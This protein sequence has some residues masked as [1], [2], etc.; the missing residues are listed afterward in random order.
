[1]C[2]LGKHDVFML[3]VTGW[4]PTM[5]WLLVWP[6]LA[7]LALCV[8]PSVALS[9]D[10][11][12][13]FDEKECALPDVWCDKRGIVGRAMRSH[14]AHK[15]DNMLYGWNRTIVL[16]DDA[17]ARA[18]MA[19]RRPRATQGDTPMF[20]AVDCVTVITLR[21]STHTHLDAFMDRVGHLFRKRLH[22]QY[23]E[24]DTIPR[25]GVWYAHTRAWREA[26]M[27]GC[28]NLLVFEDDTTFIG[29]MMQASA[30]V[31]RFLMS[32]TPYDLFML[33]F[34]TWRFHLPYFWTFPPEHTCVALAGES[35][36]VD[37]QGYIIS[38]RARERFG[39]LVFN[40]SDPECNIDYVVGVAT[41][42]VAKYTLL[43]PVA[44]QTPHKII[45]IWWGD[46][47]SEEQ[48]KHDRE[49]NDPVWV[50][51]RNINMIGAIYRKCLVGDAERDWT[52]AAWHD[53]AIYDATKQQCV[54]DAFLKEP[55]HCRKTY[56]KLMRSRNHAAMSPCGIRRKLVKDS[57]CSPDALC[58][59]DPKIPWA[60]DFLIVG[61]PKAGTTFL[62]GILGY[63]PQI[64]IPEKELQFFGTP[65]YQKLGNTWYKAQFGNIT[66]VA[67]EK[68]PFYFTNRDAI[69]QIFAANPSM[70]LVMILRDP[71]TRLFSA[72]NHIRM[73][74]EKWPNSRV[75]EYS[76]FDAYVRSLDQGGDDSNSDAGY[77]AT[78]LRA[79]WRLFPRT[80]VWI[81]I[82]ERPRDWVGLQKFLGVKVQPRLGDN[83]ARA[84]KRPYKRILSAEA[85]CTLA[86][87]YKL[88]NEE[89]FTMLGYRI[90]E[91]TTVASACRAPDSLVV[92]AT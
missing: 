82:S 78:H 38:R 54:R 50:H 71:V 44:F 41:S 21:S 90:E 5:G 15:L 36:I 4:F 7:C 34:E 27:R 75:H 85:R 12:S 47:V 68:T 14:H 87:R 73:T 58:E 26:N 10:V 1:M 57:V 43:P 77:Y 66:G 30:K 11:V 23:E 3:V 31:Q 17:D 39:G 70:R 20:G 2:V 48:L 6:G 92:G 65:E 72:Y 29:D 46:N 81:E 32:G 24:L 64:T 88:H 35:P 53:G 25:R 42:N 69:Q 52:C 16:E 9:Y 51:Q 91:W 61:V 33:G 19:S 8:R 74:H 67:G 55:P 59:N 22:V 89:L 45:N 18:Y 83:R 86:R 60:P 80:Q 13:A 56:P 62:R 40:V 37:F 84:H 49:K 28:T 76:S 63:H 79:V